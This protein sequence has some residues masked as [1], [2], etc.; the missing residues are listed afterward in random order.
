[1]LVS[2]NGGAGQELI[3]IADASLPTEDDNKDDATW[4]VGNV[5]PVSF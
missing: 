4:S 1:M 2:S 3:R 5:S